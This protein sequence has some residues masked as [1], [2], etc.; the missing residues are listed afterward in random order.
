M[1]IMTRTLPSSTTTTKDVEVSAQENRRVTIEGTWSIT[2]PVVVRDTTTTVSPPSVEFQIASDIQD[3]TSFMIRAWQRDY[4]DP[5]YLYEHVSVPKQ[6]RVWHLDRDPSRQPRTEDPLEYEGIVQDAQHRAFESE[7]RKIPVEQATLLKKKRGQVRG[8]TVLHQYNLILFDFASAELRTDHARII[9]SMIAQDGAI[10][11]YST[12][13][14]RG[15]TDSTGTADL[16]QRLS[17]ERAEAAAA[18]VRERYS[19]TLTPEAVS[20]EGIGMADVLQL[21]NGLSTPESRMYARTVHIIISNRRD[22]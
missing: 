16:N 13:V 2:Q 14:V 18:R 19:E 22:R 10:L 11:P 8:A 4:D 17:Q 3:V 20:S 5:L 12:V 1:A 6:A 15:Y 7:V 9:D 21:P